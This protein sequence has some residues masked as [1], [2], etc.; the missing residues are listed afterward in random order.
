MIKFINRFSYR[1]YGNLLAV[2]LVICFGMLVHTH[3]ELAQMRQLNQLFDQSNEKLTL[4]LAKERARKPKILLVKPTAVA[5]FSTE[6]PEISYNGVKKTPPLAF[7][8]KN[9]LNVKQPNKHTRWKGQIGR[10]KIGH[11]QFENWEMGIRASAI[12]LKN[13]AVKHQINTIE[14]LVCRFAEANHEPYM[15]FLE[16]RLSIK[17]DE[18]FNLLKRLPEVLKAM[19]R[20]ESGQE[21][22]ERYFIPYDVVSYL[23]VKEN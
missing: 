11:A 9:P 8:N 7:Q 21:F 10:D 3:Q 6:S 16:N 13:Y 4:A 5:N 23:A 17:R 1:L 2:A 12:V 20:F 22:P 15:R 18:E 19:A 14:G